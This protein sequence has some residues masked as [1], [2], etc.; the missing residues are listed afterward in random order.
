MMKNWVLQLY[1][2]LS[3]IEHIAP[4]LLSLNIK[5]V[6][7][8]YGSPP[9]LE[10]SSL[11]KLSGWHS[12]LK[13]LQSPLAYVKISA[14]YRLSKAPEFR[15]LDFVTKELLRVRDGRGVVFASDWPHTRFEGVDVGPFVERCGE[16]CGG[17]EGVWERLFRGNARVLWDVE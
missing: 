17:D 6:L 16:W 3:D 1:I 5:F 15:D 13:M 7:D 11:S 14:P 9:T 4:L 12:L 2:D 10:P 8:H